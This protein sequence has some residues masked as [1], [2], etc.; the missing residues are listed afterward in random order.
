MFIILIGNTLCV[1]QQ[2]KVVVAIGMCV[3]S[4]P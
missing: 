2:K 1:K 3:A 4:C